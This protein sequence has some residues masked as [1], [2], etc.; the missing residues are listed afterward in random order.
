MRKH[1]TGP[2]D[3]YATS[4]AKVMIYKKT[5]L[6]GRMC[7]PVRKLCPMPQTCWRRETDDADGEVV[8]WSRIV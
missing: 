8:N 5:K 1:K 7:A 3:V 2:V 6:D 4:L